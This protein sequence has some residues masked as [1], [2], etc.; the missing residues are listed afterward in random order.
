M[1]PLTVS[2]II[3]ASL[4]QVWKS[5]TDPEDIVCWN[6][7]SSDW[8]CPAARNNLA[9]GGEFA[10]TMSAKDGSVSFVFG[11]TYQHIVPEES[12]VYFIE[13]GRKV[14]VLFTQTNDGIEVTEVFE[15]EAVNSLELQV[16]GWQAILDNF[17]KHVESA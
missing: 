6:F 9:P 11:G 17:K 12:I 10:Y 7:A 16:A 14:I 3:N 13:D 8:H 2:T 15:P 1:E 4:Q 5:W